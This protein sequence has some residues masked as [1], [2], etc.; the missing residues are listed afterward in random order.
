MKMKFFIVT[1]VLFSSQAQAQKDSVQNLNAVVVTATKS[2]VYQSQTGKV[3]TV[4][5][6]EVIEKSV[7]KSLA[8]LLNEQA[9]IVINGALN[10]LGS[11]QSMYLRG[12]NVG[13]TLMLVDGIPVSDPSLINNEFDFNFIALNNVERIE[14]CKGAQSTLYGSD[15]VA[16]VVNIITV[17]KDVQKAINVK[18]TLSGGNLNTYKGNLQV[19]GG[20]DKL[21]YTVRYSKIKTD[22]F[23]AAN[24]KA[25]TNQFDKDGYNG[26]VFNASLQ[27]KITPQLLLKSFAQYSKYKTDFD[28][29]IFVDSKD[30]VSANRKTMAGAALIYNADWGSLTANY[31]HSDIARNLFDDSTDNPGYLTN[32]DFF[33][34]SD[35]VELYANIQLGKRFTILHGGDFRFN[36][37]KSITFGTYPASPWGDAGT[38]GELL[39]SSISQSSI[40]A[41]VFYKDVKDKW[42][43]DFGGRVNVNSRYGNNYTYTL[44]S[45]YKINQQVRVLGSISSAYKTPTVYQLYSSYGNPNLKVEYSQSYELGVQVDLKKLTNRLVYFYRDIQD[46]IDFN[47]IDYTYFNFNNQVAQGLEYELK[48]DPVKH[49]HLSANYTYLTVSETSQSRLNFK[50]TSYQYALRRP[51][52]NL[53]ITIGYDILPQLHVSAGG[54]YVSKRM[55]V[56]G[57]MAQDVELGD[58]FIMN[59]YSSYEVSKNV[60]LF[61]DVQNLT[62][63]RFFD[64]NGYNSIPLLFTGGLT[65][66]W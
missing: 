60:K 27:Y 53:N 62:N 43:I 11:N 22:G 31:Q 5:N 18:A 32:N 34:K 33:G 4:I 9:G 54:K 25:S 39:D 23:S 29:G 2:P 55:D 61:V 48:A 64:L 20:V 63:K 13:R 66:Q 44:S 47:N 42:N 17:N 41:S 16:G 45:S 49:L 37:M 58:Y 40:Y 59:A 36:K 65:M 3:I 14:I 35:F 1:A 7:G 57:Y 21:T 51:K 12:S 19:Y 30:Q 52:H 8:Q 26:D 56:G 28:A 15:A 50:D 46:G 38:F 6:K 24:D 10:T